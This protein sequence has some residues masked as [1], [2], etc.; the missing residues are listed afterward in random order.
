MSLSLREMEVLH[1]VV[2]TGTMSAAG[3]HL[4]ISQPAVSQL[5]GAAERRLGVRL[6]NREGN[7]LK[8]T[9]ELLELYNELELVFGNVEAARRLAALL[10]QGAGRLVRIG[11]TPALAMAFVPDAVSALKARYPSVRILMRIQEPSPIKDAVIRRDFDVGL[12]YAETFREGLDAVETCTA[13]VICLLPAGDPLADHPVLTPGHLSD[14]PLISFS[15][16][17]AMGEDLDAIFAGQQA[18]RNTFVQTGNSYM[19]VEFVRKGLGI[20]LADPFILGAVPMDGIVARPFEPVRLLKPRIVYT[21]GRQLSGP[22][23]YLIDCLRDVAKAWLARHEHVW[24]GTSAAQTGDLES[25]ETAAL[26]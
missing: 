9:D 13:R 23:H 14:R 2:K 15:H 6:F 19:S 7:R 24:T 26:S 3:R 17:S 1:A 4:R 12:V 21:K 16:V 5:V 8:P 10:D 20:G 25:T 22:E 18:R 11:A